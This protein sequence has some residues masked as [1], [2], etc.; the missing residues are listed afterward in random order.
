M[1]PI[2]VNRSRNSG[3]AASSSPNSSTT[4]RRRGSGSRRSSSAR[5]R[6]YRVTLSRSPAS[7]SSRCRRTCSPRSAVRA[8]STMVGSDWRLVISPA[9]CGSPATPANAA[10]PLK[11]TRTKESSSGGWVSA[12]A[13]TTVR[14]SSLLPEPVAPINSP[15]GP[16]P[17]SAASLRSSITGRL[18]EGITGGPDEV[19]PGRLTGWP[20]GTRRRSNA[21]RGRQPSVWSIAR[22]L[23]MP[24]TSSRREVRVARP[25]AGRSIGSS[26]QSGARRRATA[27]DTARL[28]RSA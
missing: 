13:V 10:P 26:S 23:R 24:S 25:T 27:S 11:S 28:A 22:G 3:W 18:E 12:S 16:M 14:S 20:M 8:R 1:R 4:T 17:P 9:V 15:C 19:S 7:R 21:G 5:S 6:W 2:A